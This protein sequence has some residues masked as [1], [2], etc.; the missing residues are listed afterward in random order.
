MFFKKFYTMRA[1]HNEWVAGG[2][3]READSLMG[4]CGSV[5]AKVMVM[6]S[7]VKHECQAH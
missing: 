5:M 6:S 2:D 1:G 7:D 3:G 4:W